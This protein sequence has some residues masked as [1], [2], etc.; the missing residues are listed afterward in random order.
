MLYYLIGGRFR[1]DNLGG[2]RSHLLYPLVPTTSPFIHS[3]VNP[4]FIT[5]C[6]LVLHPLVQNEI[7]QNGS[8]LTSTYVHKISLKERSRHENPPPSYAL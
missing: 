6:L 5:E 4:I 1:G 2:W 7:T 3:I 8:D